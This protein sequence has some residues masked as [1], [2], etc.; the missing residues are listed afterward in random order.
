[1]LRRPKLDARLGEWAPLTVVRGLHGAGKTTQVASW[2]EHQSSEDL[3]PVWVTAHLVTG[4]P[5]S[6]LGGL[7]R[8]LR[9]APAG[10][11]GPGPAPGEGGGLVELDRALHAVAA[12]RKL[13]LVIDN[14]QH[15]RHELL[16]AE[17]V[18]L[19]ERHRAFHLVVCCR[20]RHPIESLA[21]GRV[22]VNIVESKELL[23][24]VDEI[25]ALGRLMGTELD[26]PG[27][28]RLRESVGPAIAALRLALHDSGRAG[29]KSAAAE[30]Y[31]R[32]RILADIG[33]DD[34]MEHLMRLALAEEVTWPLVRDLC[35][36][37]RPDRL[38]E[39]LE[40]TGIME[41]DPWLGGRFVVSAPFRRVLRERFEATAPEAAR[42]FHR[43]LAGWFARQ[44]DDV[45]IP[46]AFYHAVAAGDWPLADEL[47]SDNL[48]LLIRRST[49]LLRDTL[50]RIPLPVLEQR[51]AMQVVHATLQR[52]AADTDP[53]RRGTVRA[54]ADACGRSVRRQ[55]DTMTPNDLLIV[56]TGFLVGLRLSGRFQDSAS[57]GDRIQAR[58]GVA[59]ASEHLS[60]SR[61]AWF[62]LQRGITDVLIGDNA[63]AIRACWRA[64]EGATAP[65]DDVIRSEAAAVMALSF[66]LGGESAHARRWLSLHRGIDVGDWPG[67]R[68]VEIGGHVAAGLL[69]L[70]R[71]D[72]AAVC[73]ELEVLDDAPEAFELW[74]F[75]A[76]LRAQ[77]ALHLG[78]APEAL[79]QLDHTEA[80]H[81]AGLCDKGAA[82]ALLARARADLLVACGRGHR[83][84]HL[85]DAR[86][87]R[88]PLVRV[89]A[90]RIRLIGG[91]QWPGTDLAPFTWDAGTSIRDRLEMLLLGA[92]AAMRSGD[93]RSIRR[94]VN[95]ALDLY[96]DTGILRP[97]AT[98]APGALADLLDFG[99]R[100][101]DP[102]DAKSIDA[103]APVYPE[104]LEL[105]DLTDREQS[106]LEALA[107]SD[108]RQA[109]AD[110]LFVSVNTVKT[111]LGS[112]HQKLGSTT[113]AETLATA[114][115]LEL[116]PWDEPS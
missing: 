107:H 110:S 42:A 33:D 20:G 96:G 17:L 38:L 28:L 2:L 44:D 62:H 81:E 84:Q 112:I 26:I 64:W 13:V 72:D 94:L 15:V 95:Q 92:L 29:E 85:V 69:A 36:E 60:P 10:A 52:A 99:E 40:S 67:H 88:T 16:L 34:L 1:V 101:L 49:C 63:N 80:A 55:W 53:A 27:A 66:A 54:F 57:F 68:I 103:R 61:L 9:S 51:A 75:I 4:E 108:S 116:L 91:G 82:A 11:G 12:G 58:V 19:V 32:T 5:D 59:G 100:G 73:A 14:F 79:A 7:S 102:D 18:D 109:I 35:D 3:L 74:P 47:W 83:A 43:R 113:R 31:V 90:A 114:R 87:T 70:D 104:T 30:E 50:A 23:L 65:S 8:A 78:R 46:S 25:V 106:V 48:T 98:V 93:T 56:G 71:L 45:G 86:E 89:P 105:V 115:R 41:R 77:H 111:Q 39:E 37:A 6:L 21:A 97:F 22:D 76:F 24:E